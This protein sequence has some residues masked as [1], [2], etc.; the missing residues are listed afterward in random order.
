MR[1]KISIGVFLILFL[2]LMFTS[3]CGQSQR[4]KQLYLIKAQGIGDIIIK[5]ASACFSQAQ[6]Y[7]ATW[8]YA[9]VTEMDYATAARELQGPQAQQN[10]AMMRENMAKIDSLLQSLSDPPEEFQPAHQ[11]LQELYDLYIEIHKLVEKPPQDMESFFESLPP[12]EE[13]LYEKYNELNS[14]LNIEQEG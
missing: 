1:I 6:S 13:E 10:K 11:A 7:R 9:K 2:A 8:E 5:Q 4:Q 3:F 14:K 12:L